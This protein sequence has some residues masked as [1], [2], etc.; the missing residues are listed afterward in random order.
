M[1]ER[2]VK[3]ARNCLHWVSKPGPLRQH[4]KGECLVVPHGL[5][6]QASENNLGPNPISNWIESSKTNGIREAHTD[7]EAKP[8]NE[9]MFQSLG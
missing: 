9:Q 4:H 8:E 2:P 5:A 6:E 1:P 7:K 3:P